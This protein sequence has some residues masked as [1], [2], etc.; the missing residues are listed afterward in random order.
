MNEIQA[1]NNSF[2]VEN[3]RYLPQEDLLRK[4]KLDSYT[5]R[6]VETHIGERF[7]VLLSMVRYDIKNGQLYPEGMDEPICAFVFSV[8]GSYFDYLRLRA[9]GISAEDARFL[10]PTATKTEVYTTFN[11]RM[12]MHFFKMRC[13]THAQWEIRD[14]A[15]QMRNLFKLHLECLLPDMATA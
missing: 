3:Y 4:E 14:L 7:N 5:K 15:C 1:Y 6:Q 8:A 13:D 2:D 10:L 9:L 11:L 12:W